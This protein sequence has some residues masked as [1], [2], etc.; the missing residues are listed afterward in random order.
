VRCIDARPDALDSERYSII[1]D[2]RF[3]GHFVTKVRSNATPAC[4]G[5]AVLEERKTTGDAMT[6][7]HHRKNFWE[8]LVELIGIEPTTSGLQS[9]RSPS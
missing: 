6:C 8:T 5:L 4:N 3:A 7:L 1:K 9:P 2:R